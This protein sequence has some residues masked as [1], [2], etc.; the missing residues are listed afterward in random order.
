MN[1]C[2]HNLAFAQP[3]GLTQTSPGS[4]RPTPATLGQ[5]RQ[6]PRA[7]KGRRNAFTLVDMMVILVLLALLALCLLMPGYIRAKAKA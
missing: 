7:L 2:P 1:D 5:R 6:N 4:G 3:E